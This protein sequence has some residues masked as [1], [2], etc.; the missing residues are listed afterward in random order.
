VTLLLDGAGDGLGHADLTGAVFAAPGQRRGHS[1]EGL[2]EVGSHGTARTAAYCR[3][4]DPTVTAAECQHCG[5]PWQPDLAGA[6]RFCK[7]V[8]PPPG[9][10][11]AWTGDELDATA[12]FGLLQ[13]LKAEGRLAAELGRHLPDQASGDEAHLRLAVEDWRYERDGAA[14]QAVHTVRGV[15]LKREALELDEWVA[16]VAAHLAE[17]AGKNARVRDGLLALEKGT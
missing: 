15:V 3:P 12:L 2:P 17:Y 14:S 8:A 7:T 9:A 10:R 11:P 13:N 1:R 4:G 16:V 6:C 5:A